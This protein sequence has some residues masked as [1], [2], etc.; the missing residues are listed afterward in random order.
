MYNPTTGGIH[1]TRDV[2]WLRRM[3]YQKPLSPNEFQV[4]DNG[5]VHNDDNDL[6]P[7]MRTP[8]L[9]IESIDAL[10]ALDVAPNPFPAP[11]LHHPN[12][13]EEEDDDMVDNQ[14]EEENINQQLQ[15]EPDK[16]D[17]EE[18]AILPSLVA[19]T[20]TVIRSGRISRGAVQFSDKTP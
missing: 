19:P 14:H 11:N 7:Q 2:L 8:M 17:E 9:D 4:L 20:V 18:A 5:L 6:P 16:Q 1:E 10:E 15:Q 3:Y 13:V 12:A